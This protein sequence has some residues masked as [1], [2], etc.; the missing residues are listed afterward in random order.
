MFKNARVT[1][2]LTVPM[3]IVVAGLMIAVAIIYSTGKKTAPQPA[4]VKDTV[5]APAPSP[6]AENVRPITSTDHVFGY[7][8][9][10][11]KVVES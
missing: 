5:N 2:F 11:V 4:S 10:Q 8:N 1:G 7:P 6:A 3:A 9:A